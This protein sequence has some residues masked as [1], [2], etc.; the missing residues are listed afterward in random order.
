MGENNRGMKGSM[1]IWKLLCTHP[2]MDD[3]DKIEQFEISDLVIYLI[4]YTP[5]APGVQI[6][7]QYERNVEED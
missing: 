2:D 1:N 6:L 7:K 3:D 5:Q 4:I